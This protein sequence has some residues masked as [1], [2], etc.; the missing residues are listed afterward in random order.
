MADGKEIIAQLA[1]GNMLGNQKAE[2]RAMANDGE[3]SLG[4]FIMEV[5]GLS[6]RHNPQD[7]SVPS[8]ALIGPAKFVP[9]K[10][11]RPELWAERAFLP[12][13]VH[14]SIVAALE[15]DNKRPVDKSPGRK[16]KAIN[17]PLGAT[18]PIVMEIGVISKPDTA[19]GYVYTTKSSSKV[20]LQLNDP[21]A[22]LSKQAGVKLLDGP[23]SARTISAPQRPENEGSG[24]KSRAKKK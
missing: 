20:P 16:D 11:D 1:P 5:R 7:E 6:Y 2:V 3:L 13:T 21:L 22:A 18:M 17:I 23:S 19:V 12:N 9:N 4:T 15:G 8:I 24:S 10:T 14:N